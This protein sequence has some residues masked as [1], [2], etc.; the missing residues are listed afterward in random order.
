[1]AYVEATVVAALK[2][3]GTLATLVDSEVRVPVSDVGMAEALHSVVFHY[4]MSALH[5]RLS[6]REGS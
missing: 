4:A 1:M 5:E 2:A 6:N 3:N